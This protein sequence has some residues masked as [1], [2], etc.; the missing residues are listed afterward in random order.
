MPVVNIVLLIIYVTVTV[1]L[2]YHLWQKRPPDSVRKKLY[3][4]IVILLPWVGWLAYGAL[5]HPLKPNSTRPSGGA[6][7]WAPHHRN[8]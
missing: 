6:S 5:Y 4:S 7:G 3:W 2:L 8:L 1:A